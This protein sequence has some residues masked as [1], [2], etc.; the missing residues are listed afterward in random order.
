MPNILVGQI[1]A[2]TASAVLVGTSSAIA[3][4]QNLQRVGLIVTN[5]STSTIYLGLSGSAATLKSGITLTPSG[6]AFSMDDYTFNNEVITAIAHTASS[7]L[8]VQEFVR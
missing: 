4:D 1:R 8:A 7:V 6:G 2:L 5:V 3:V